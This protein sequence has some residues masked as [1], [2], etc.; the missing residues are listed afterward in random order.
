MRLV[1]LSGLLLAASLL[2][3]ACAV[4][5]RAPAPPSDTR[6]TACLDGF[7]AIDR[8]VAEQGITPS[9][10]ARIA[11]FPYLR[12]N[13]FLA[14][15]RQQAL[16]EAERRVWLARLAELDAQAR[17]IE[18][19]SLPAAYRQ[20]LLAGFP[21]SQDFD[22][23]LDACYRRLQAHDLND[24]ERWAELRDRAVV[25]PDYRTLNQILGLY[26][27]MAL[28][29]SYG[30]YRWQTETRDLFEQPLEALSVQGTLRRFQPPTGAPPAT[31]DLAR[32][33]LGIPKPTP[34][35]LAALYALHAPVW[36]IDV[37]G[38]FDLPGKPRWQADGQPT[39]DSTR[40]VTYRYVTY[41]RWQGKALLQLNYVIWFAERPRRGTFDILGGPL[42]GLVWRVTLDR[43]L[44][45][46][47]YDTIHNCGCYHQFFPGSRLQLR[48]E[49]RQLPE[50]P[51]VLQA[52]PDLAAGERVVI[53]IESGSHYLQRVHAAEPS[54]TPYLWRDYAAL[55]TLPA[56]HGKR[57]LF[58]PD[59]L[60]AGS[61]RGERWLLWP[62]GVPSPG[63]MRERGRHATA[64]VG[65]RHFDDADLLENLFEPIPG[66]H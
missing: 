32:D 64:F 36:E 34:A 29:V 61:E 43:E 48:A 20:L 35:Q 50:P 59:G 53:R 7:A 51:L 60:V 65:R 12:V 45:P 26:P 27:L 40:P 1:K 41:T 66:R 2:L 15:Y 28:P 24:T 3:N 21:D 8:A 5:P 16:T 22:A 23:A 37:A 44:T 19:K 54:G 57:S 6:T 49:A 11:G 39:V 31:F 10:P 30:V 55:Y 18:L 52:A 62:M 63:A 42:S 13:R 47:L 33:A 38:D 58:G 17:H 25:P 46:L 56:E 9:S 14:S 4:T